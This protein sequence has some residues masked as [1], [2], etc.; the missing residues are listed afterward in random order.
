MTCSSYL[1]VCAHLCPTL[2]ELMA[3]ACQAP[4]SMKFSKQEYQNELPFPT[5]GDL[6]DPGIELVSPVSPALAVRFFTT[7]PPRKS[8]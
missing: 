2:C 8:F 1:C 4:L 7:V 5:A 6:L 3:L